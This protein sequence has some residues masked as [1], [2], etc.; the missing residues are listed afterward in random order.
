MF[1]LKKAVIVGLG[2]L[3]STITAATVNHFPQFYSSD[4]PQDTCGERSFAQVP[5]KNATTPCCDALQSDIRKNYGQYAIGGFS[6]D[7]DNWMTIASYGNCALSFRPASQEALESGLTWA[8]GSGDA[9][10]L[11]TDAVEMAF[12]NGEGA[13][14]GV[15]PCFDPE[16]KFWDLYWRVWDARED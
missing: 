3:A 12:Q 15:V 16:K 2:T 14:E 11:V 7:N 13:A 1:T 6:P 8:I 9:Y 5:I 4:R 10:L